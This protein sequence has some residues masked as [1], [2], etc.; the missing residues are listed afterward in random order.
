MLK[1]KL[2]PYLLISICYL[3]FVF[4]YKDFLFRKF[5]QNIIPNY[6]R[7]QDIEDINDEIK[8]RIIVSDDEIYQAAGFLYTKGNPPTAY[9]FQHPPLIKYLFGYSSKYFN[10]PVLPNVFFGLVLL[11][12]VYILGKLVFKKHEVGL[13]ASILLLIDPVFKEV[14]IYSLLDL[15]QIVFIL[16]FLIT[17]I[18]YSKKYVLS[19]ILLGLAAASKFYSPILVFLLVIYLYKILNKKLN[20]KNELF[21]LATAFIVFSLI[22]IKTLPLNPI[23]YQARIIKFM[24]NHN[25]ST[26][27]GRVV[28]MFTN[29]YILW[30]L[31]LAT[32]VV[33]L[34]KQ[35]VKTVKFFIFLLPLTYFLVMT[36]QLPFTRYFILITP[37]LYLAFS[38]GL[39][40]SF[41]KVLPIFN[42][43]M[44]STKKTPKKSSNSIKKS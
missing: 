30:P 41:S 25:Q 22:Y 12:E 44:K 6:L 10:L 7:S 27:W 19:G 5:D 43:K 40:L 34:F 17:T 39:L 4:T 28:P 29:G 15:G 31:S 9:N 26:S 33:L 1:R 20:I 35:K 3:V 42:R 36:F 37:F 21:T 13:L 8:D 32:S 18:F 24:V 11:F 2:F 38:E 14:T 23:Y 16:G